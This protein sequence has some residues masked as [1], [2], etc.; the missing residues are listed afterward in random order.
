MSQQVNLEMSYTTYSNLCDAVEK[1]ATHAEDFDDIQELVHLVDF[2]EEEYERDCGKQ[3]WIIK[4][5]NC[6]RSYLEIK[7]YIIMN[8]FIR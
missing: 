6:M 8:I 5:G 3:I 4:P 7:S 1:A 2:L